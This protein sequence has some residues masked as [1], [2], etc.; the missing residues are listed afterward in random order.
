VEYFDVHGE[1][2]PERGASFIMGENE[3]AF[4]H[5]QQSLKAKSV[6]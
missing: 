1:M 6:V 5:I 2:Y 3:I 4:N